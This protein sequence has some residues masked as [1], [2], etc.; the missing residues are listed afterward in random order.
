MVAQY[1]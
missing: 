1:R